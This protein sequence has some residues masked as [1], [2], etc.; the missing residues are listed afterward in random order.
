M[1]HIISGVKM[2]AKAAKNTKEESWPEKQIDTFE[3]GAYGSEISLVETPTGDEALKI[4]TSRKVTKE[5]TKVHKYGLWMPKKLFGKWISWLNGAMIK[6]ATLW[7]VQLE[8]QK[9]VEYYKDLAVGYQQKYDEAREKLKVAEEKAVMKEEELRLARQVV[10][11]LDEYERSYEELVEEVKKQKTSG[12]RDEIRIKDMLYK[13][14]WMLGL[15]CVVKAKEKLIDTQ[16]AIDM[17][18]QTELGQD[19]I[20]EFKSS[21][22]D[23]FR[24]KKNDSRLEADPD[25]TEGINQLIEYLQKTDYRSTQA[26]PGGYG[27]PKAVGTLII[28]YNLDAEQM[29]LLKEWGWHLKPHVEIRTYNDLID[30]SKRQLENIRFAR[31]AAERA[32]NQT[33]TPK[34]EIKN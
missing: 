3:D 23:P 28:G 20:Y 31:N 13:Y 32:D 19:K 6:I 25:F 22:L 7:G 33:V 10:D 2:A 30:S 12:K 14:R 8:P 18:I 11:D 5:Y 27:M 26:V 15:D 9:E 21:A 29:R 16:A 1:S 34:Q 4:K 17:H 24:K